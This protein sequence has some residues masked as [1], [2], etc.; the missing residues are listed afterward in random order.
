MRG[1]VVGGSAVSSV[2]VGWAVRF[3]LLESAMRV[4]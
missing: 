4:W 1:S 3:V 2:V